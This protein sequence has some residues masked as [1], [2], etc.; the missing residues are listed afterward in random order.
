MSD[1]VPEPDPATEPVDRRFTCTVCGYA[2]THE[3]ARLSTDTNATCVNC[4]DWTVRTADTEAII[5][6]AREIADAVAGPVLSE[7]QALAYLLRDHVGLTRQDAADAMDSSASN[8]DNLQRRGR[9]KV[10]AARQL[11]AD[12]DALASDGADSG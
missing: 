3:V 10:A 11:V 12:L 8:V 9:E 6:D 2:T 1:A 4:G 5:D 7:R